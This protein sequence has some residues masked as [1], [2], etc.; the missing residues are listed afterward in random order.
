[1]CTKEITHDLNNGVFH[2][3]LSF[4]LPATFCAPLVWNTTNKGLIQFLPMYIPLSQYL[5]HV[6]SSTC[7]LFMYLF[8][9]AQETSCGIWLHIM[10]ANEF[11][12]MLPTQNSGN[13]LPRSYRTIEMI[14]SILQRMAKSFTLATSSSV[15]NYGIFCDTGT[16]IVT[17]SIGT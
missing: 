2:C 16:F 3:L 14:N 8:S 17:W 1:M 4:L 13:V 15:L 9:T 12:L 11:I 10:A 6:L 5:W 7:T